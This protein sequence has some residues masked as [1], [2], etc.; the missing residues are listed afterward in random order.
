M[1]QL[2][3]FFVCAAVV[4][5]VDPLHGGLDKLSAYR[6]EFR[7][8]DSGFVRVFSDGIQINSTLLQYGVGHVKQITVELTSFQDSI[9]VNLEL[10]SQLFGAKYSEKLVHRNH[11]VYLNGS[12]NQNDLHCYYTGQVRGDPRSTAA[13]STC[14]GLRGY[15]ATESDGFH[16]EPSPADPAPDLR[17][18]HFIFRDSDYVG[19]SHSCGHKDSEQQRN[20]VDSHRVL[21]RSLRWPY[22]VDEKTMIV[23][24]Y[25]AND[26][27]QLSRFHQDAEEVIRRTKDIVNIVS[28][29]YRPL[30]IY[31]ALV[32][33]EVWMDKNEIEIVENADKTMNNFLEYRRQRISPK[34]PNDNAQLITGQAL[35]DGVV[36]KAPIMTICTWQYSGGVNLDH[37]TLVG[38]VATTVAHEM[39]HNFGLI[40]DTETCG[41]PDDRCIMAPSSGGL[42]NPTKWSEC[43]KQQFNDA[44]HQGMDYCLHNLPPEIQVGSVCGNGFTEDGEQCDCG[45]PQDCTSTCCNATTCR[46]LPNATC[47]VGECCEQST[48]QPKPMATE[49][50]K[51]SGYC[52]LAEYCNG[53]SEYCPSDIFRQDGTECQADRVDSYCYKGHCETHDAQC[54]LLWGKT[55]TVSHRLCFEQFNTMGTANGHCGFNWIDGK[56]FKKCEP[57]DV[58]CGMLHCQHRNEKL[59]FW[60]EA[61]AYALPEA[62]IV[63]NSTRQDCKGVILDVG[64]DMPDP[65]MVPDGT[66]CGSRKMCVSQQCRD[67]GSLGLPKCPNCN[68]HGVC[69]SLGQCHCDPFYAPPFCERAGNGGSEH[70]GP[71]EIFRPNV[72]LIVGM[73]F[74]FLVIL[75]LV[76]VLAFCGYR[77]HEKIKRFWL[78]QQSDKYRSVYRANPRN[79]TERPHS[80][81]VRPGAHPPPPARHPPDAEWMKSP[82]VAVVGTGIPPVPCRPIEMKRSPNFRSQEFAGPR[83]H[84]AAGSSNYPLVPMEKQKTR[85]GSASGLRG[86]PRSAPAPCGVVAE[87]KLVPTRVAPAPPSAASAKHL[88]TVCNGVATLKRPPKHP[89]L[90]QHAKTPL[91]AAKTSGASSSST[92][93]RYSG[94]AP[95]ELS[96]AGGKGTDE[97]EFYKTSS[98]SSSPTVPPPDP[99]DSRHRFYSSHHRPFG[100]QASSPGVGSNTPFHSK[101]LPSSGCRSKTD[102]PERRT[103]NGCNPHRADRPKDPR[104]ARPA[105]GASGAVQYP[106]ISGHH[107]Q[108]ASGSTVLRSQNC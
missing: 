66:K 105:K 5:V 77:H 62:W 10:N 100:G 106:N 53:V 95:E 52:D 59:M 63:V 98:I 81:I 24:L 15:V 32:G 36:G 3:Q 9:V 54:K 8:F 76:T 83:L 13:L 96:D 27:S 7:Q 39:G 84:G 57:R 1:F 107:Q 6:Q 30:N 103:E 48:C 89:L 58:M 80:T 14:G 99:P 26:R 94:V 22:D 19:S 87:E 102:V 56:T 35:G 91:N 65:G 12:I 45:L 90:P 79:D 108:P 25:V 21:R 93:S 88:E 40:H 43:S 23:E 28:S 46:L 41:C 86:H 72:G 16:V 18:R 33:V 51:S 47:A 20:I 74:F 101:H 71:T 92:V 38:P 67:I 55:G 11:E 42:K 68:G 82:S 69:N 2:S 104:P 61:L 34:H 78:A 29:L 64:L 31:V 17:G 73:C 75:P 37:S 70:S 60:K 44:F 85:N 97:G 4:S 50:R 49:C